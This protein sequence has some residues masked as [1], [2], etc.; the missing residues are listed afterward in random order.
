MSYIIKNTNPFVSIKLTEKGRGQLALG[1]LNFTSWAIGDSELNYNRE[2]IV[3][4]NQSDVTLSASSIIMRPFDRQPNIKSYIT[5]LNAVTPYQPLD[6]SNMN[7][8]KAVVCNEATERGFFSLSGGVYTTL[9]GNTYSPYNQSMPNIYLTGGTVL[10]G[11]VS[12]SGFSVGDI[13]LLKLINNLATNSSTYSLGTASGFVAL[14]NNSLTL[15][16]PQFFTTGD[17]GE[18]T[19]V[20]TPSFGTGSDQGASPAAVADVVSLYNTLILLTGTTIITPSDLG[21]D[22]YGYGTGVFIPGVYSITGAIDTTVTFPNI[23]L[24]GA[25]DYVF[26]SYS[27]ALTTADP[28]NIILTGGATSDK[29]FWVMGTAI[30][31]GANGVLK[32]NFMSGPTADIT[33]GSTNT[34]EGRLLSQNDITIDGTASS[35]TLPSGSTSSGSSSI[36]VGLSNIS[37]IPNLWFK[38]QSLNANSVT[39]DRNLPNYS[40]YTNDSLVIIYRGGEVYNTIATGDTTAYW[41]SGT[42][43]FDASSNITC[44]DVPVWNMNNVWCENLAGMTGLTT[45]QL[46][47]DYTKFGSYQYLGTKN[48]YLEYFCLSTADTLSFPC[49][50]PGLSYSDDVS[51][52]IS[53]IHYTNNTISSLYGEYFV[54]DTTNS[55]TLRITLPDLMYYRRGYPTGSGTTMGMSFLASGT[56]KFIGVSDIEYIDLIEDPTLISSATTAHVVGRVFPQLK[57]VVISNDEIVAAISYKSNRNWT[58]PK[59]A[60]NVASPSGG[61]S[62]GVLAVN[63]TIYLTYSLENT[64]STGLT[65]SLSTQDYVKVTNTTNAPKDIAFRISETDLLP[66]MR[67]YESGYD[68]FGFYANKFKLVYQIVQDPN[69]RPDP[70]A[71]KAYDF[72]TT[73]ITSGASE[74]IDPKLLENQNPLVTGFVLDTL[75]DATAST[76]D[77]TQSLMMAANNSPSSLQFGD[78]RFFYGNLTTFIGATIFKTI[79]DIRV[80]SGLFN[81]TTNPTRSTDLTTN[82]PNIKISEVGIYDSNNNLVCIGKVSSPVA[83]EVGNTIMLELSMDF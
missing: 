73:A 36:S 40:A 51:K 14:A 30:T 82:P 63:N 16:S 1:Q 3:D 10:N 20:G 15:T 13:M 11:F 54:I 44:H 66:Y 32:G 70:G 83:L 5:P 62:T 19:L 34:L 76:F 81:A 23:I 25:G 80:F 67:K 6:A 33:I 79:F 47:E 72:T 37:P 27:G 2:E 42:L 77:I 9:T 17:I 29:V 4:A 74:T 60:A 69:E 41:D 71:W 12:T 22:D 35:F 43:S 68:G 53:I 8:I 57:M 52:S 31:T 64:A 78:E 75:K 58:L 28:V 7:V 21:S 26:I 65:T 38:I 55:K 61:T 50:E 45:T 48:P 24:S 46:Y 56:T 39:V 18:T 49:D 59:L